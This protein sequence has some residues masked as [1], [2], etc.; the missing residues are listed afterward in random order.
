VSGLQD[1]IREC[2]DTSVRFLEQGNYVELSDMLEYE[3]APKLL[4]MQEGV[5]RMINVAERKLN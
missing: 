5:Y 3:L 2:L 1:E 4:E